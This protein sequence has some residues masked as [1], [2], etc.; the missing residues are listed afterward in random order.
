[1]LSVRTAIGPTRNETGGSAPSR[2][3]STRVAVTFAASGRQSL[4]SEST[5]A[6]Y[7]ATDCAPAVATLIAT[8]IATKTTVTRARLYIDQGPPPTEHREQSRRREDEVERARRD[9]Q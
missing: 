5:R 9:V 6:R 8:L 2:E 3:L 1:M 7:S 4:A